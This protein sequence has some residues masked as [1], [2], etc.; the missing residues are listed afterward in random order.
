MGGGLLKL[1]PTEAGRVLVA[2][3]A[4][5]S[6]SDPCDFL[7]RL[8]RH[9]P[10][11]TVQGTVDRLLLRDRL[12]LTETECRCLRDAAERLRARRLGGSR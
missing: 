1:E 4:H 11:K 2:L 5:D 12:G 3:P 6:P 7:D 9:M 8:A 10:S